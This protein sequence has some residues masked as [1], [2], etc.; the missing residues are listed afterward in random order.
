[1]GKRLEP[2]T[3]DEVA[4]RLREAGDTV[5]RLPKPRGPAAYGS[6]WPDVVRDAREAYGY[7]EGSIRPAAPTPRAIDRMME[8]F[9]WFQFLEGNVE[10]M[11]AM[12]IS[13]G[14]G[15]SFANTARMFG[16]HRKTVGA[17][18]WAAVRRIAHGLNGD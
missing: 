3:D 13:L 11:R 2:W 18:T 1:M 10:E 8:V 16:V 17:R 7:T 9:T 14:C 6:G 5:R 12:W 15:V 4:A